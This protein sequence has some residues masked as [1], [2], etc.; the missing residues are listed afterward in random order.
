MK[1]S[2]A[3]LLGGKLKPTTTR[4]R[5]R[6]GTVLEE[7]KDE[8]GKVVA[9]YVGKEILPAFLTDASKGMGR[10]SAYEF[11]EER[12]A[13]FVSPPAFSGALPPNLS[14]V[15]YNVWFKEYYMKER[16][17]A[18]IE[19]LE[20]LEPRPDIIAFQEVTP[21]FQNCLIMHAWVRRNFFVSDI[22]GS[23]VLPYGVMMLVN[24]SLPCPAFQIHSLPSNMARR[25]LHAIFLPETSEWNT[26]AP[27]S[28][29]AVG[30][31]HLESMD[32][33]AMRVEQLK[34]ICPL[35]EYSNNAILM[36]DTNYPHG[37]EAES[38]VW[39]EHKSFADVWPLLYP[40]DPNRPTGLGMHRIDKVFVKSVLYRATHQVLL[41]SEPFRKNVDQADPEMG[42]D[43][44]PSDHLGLH[45]LLHSALKIS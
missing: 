29:L 26:D 32:N 3:M 6:D 2:P 40:S 42:P 43:L 1:I 8:N 30:T 24:R 27:C 44:Y 34:L 14:L 31:A 25:F 9:T 23:T 39:S 35:L 17:D 45:T 12:S 5:H 16:F 41:G 10:L 28:A 13:W 36:G 33:T 20:H 21:Y 7:T 18:L 15:S 22:N 19:I 37:A 38:Q 4:V 11:S